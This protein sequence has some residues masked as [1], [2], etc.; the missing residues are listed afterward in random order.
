MSVIIKIIISATL[1]SL[2]TIS[3]ASENEK[4]LHKALVCNCTSKFVLP[5][6]KAED[7]AVVVSM[8]FIL[9]H[10]IELVSETRLLAFLGNKGLNNAAP[11]K[12]L[13]T[14]SP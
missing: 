11:I 12:Q 5:K 9:Q 1:H 8:Q 13:I 14:H 2:F 6:S 7:P 4:K 3:S 10:I